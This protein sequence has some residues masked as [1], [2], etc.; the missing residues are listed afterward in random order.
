MTEIS[1][2]RKIVLMMNLGVLTKAGIAHFPPT[3]GCSKLGEEG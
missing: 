2:I 3:C 1:Q